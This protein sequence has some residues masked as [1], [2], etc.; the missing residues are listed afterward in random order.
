M[1]YSDGML[2]VPN[3]QAVCDC[4]VKI[5]AVTLHMHRQSLHLYSDDALCCFD[6]GWHNAFIFKPD[7]VNVHSL[8]WSFKI[9]NGF[10][11]ISY[12]TCKLRWH[13]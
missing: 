12:L 3:C 9:I 10:I 11:F 8:I 4:L 7:W 1:F 6:K 5:F 2:P 13:F